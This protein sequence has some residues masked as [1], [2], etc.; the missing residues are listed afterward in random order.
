MKPYA[1]RFTDMNPADVAAASAICDYT[2]NRYWTGIRTMLAWSPKLLAHIKSMAN[3]VAEDKNG[4]IVGFLL[5]E[6]FPDGKPPTEMLPDGEPPT[7]D[8][9]AVAALHT[10][11]KKRQLCVNWSL[12]LFGFTRCIEQGIKEGKGR[13]TGKDNPVRAVFE[14]VDKYVVREGESGPTV[15]PHET[16]VH[17]WYVSVK[18]IDEPYRQA[19]EEAIARL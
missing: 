8:V 10:L 3:I 13:I 19:L 5:M 7:V 11:S 6:M 15:V 14:Q 4:K 17:R 9:H 16:E 12:L 18:P 2:Q 1:C